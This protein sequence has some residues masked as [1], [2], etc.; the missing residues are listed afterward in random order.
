MIYIFFS[1]SCLYIIDPT[2]L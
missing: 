2:A 1:Y